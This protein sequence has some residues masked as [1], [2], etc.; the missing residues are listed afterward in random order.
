MQKFI[1]FAYSYT[2]KFLPDTNSG[3]CFQLRQRLL[4][5]A[6]E[7]EPPCVIPLD[8]SHLNASTQQEQQQQLLLGPAIPDWMHNRRYG[9][10]DLIVTDDHTEDVGPLG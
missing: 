4:H 8:Q 9:T 7:S 6:A 3:V 1:Y 10:L 2:H 5:P